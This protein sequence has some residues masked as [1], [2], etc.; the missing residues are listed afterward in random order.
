MFPAEKFSRPLRGRA[1]L[2]EHAGLEAGGTGRMRR[3]AMR[4]EGQRR[5]AA[6]GK[7]GQERQRESPPTGGRRAKSVLAKRVWSTQA[8]DGSLVYETAQAYIEE[9][10]QLD[11]LVHTHLALPVQDVPEPLFVSSDAA[12]KLGGAD[13]SLL[14]LR[15]NEGGNLPTSSYR[16]RLK[17]SAPRAIP[18]R[19]SFSSTIAGDTRSR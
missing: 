3:S 16:H 7:P 14:S 17:L 9:G 2:G 11:K 1:V 12:C 4:D 5:R 15:L 6:S 8:L 18:T 10:A 13:T 19:A